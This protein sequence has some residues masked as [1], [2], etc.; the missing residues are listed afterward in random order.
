MA[1][2]QMVL[3]FFADEAAAD[4][5]AKSLLTWEKKNDV[6]PR[7]VGV[8]VADENGRIKE[9]RLGTRSSKMGAGIGA[10]LAVIAPPTV[11]AGMVGGAI[12][13]HFHHKGLGL[14]DADRE[15]IAAEL[16]G[17]RAAIGVLVDED[18]EAAMISNKLAEL[19]GTPEVHEVTEEALE[20]IA[21]A[22]PPEPEAAPSPEALTRLGG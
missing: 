8:L 1:V 18:P 19:G 11:L 20:A 6:M 12:L 22:A 5:A 9:H 10:V 14:T 15:R 4:A 21:A 7:P 13:G 16:A 3:A 2:H 17:G